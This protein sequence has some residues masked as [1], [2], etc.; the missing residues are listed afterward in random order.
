MS[1]QYKQQQA[2]LIR[3]VSDVENALASKG[4]VVNIMNKPDM[5]PKQLEQASANRALIEAHLFQNFRGVD[6]LID[7]TFDSL[8]RT[9]VSLYKSGSLKA[10]SDVTKEFKSVLTSTTGKPNHSHRDELK[11]TDLVTRQRKAAL[12]A[13]Q[14]KKAA[15][16]WQTV[17]DFC[18]TYTYGNGRSHGQNGRGREILRKIAADL[19]QRG[20]TNPEMAQ[21]ALNSVKKKAAALEDELRWGA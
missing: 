18:S 9:V 10:E 1:I 21:A 20:E 6:G 16:I 17:R 11:S 15:Q 4:R 7:A 12:D 2:E 3:A 14:A 5:T 8:W 19:Y 13:E